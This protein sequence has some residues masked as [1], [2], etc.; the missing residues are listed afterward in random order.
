M[1]D[2][3]LAQGIAA[4]KA[5]NVNEA[6]KLLDIAIRAAPDD[7]RTWGWFYNVCV[8]DEERTRCL[9]QVIRINPNNEIAKKKLGELAAKESGLNYQPPEPPALL[10]SLENPKK[11]YR[12]STAK[13]LTFMFCTPLWTLI[14]IED[15]DSSTAVKIVAIILLLVYGFFFCRLF[16]GVRL[17]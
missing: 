11:W 5:G 12:S 7:E 3:Y 4:V 10:A 8:N 15:P 2:D 6:R 1:A 13:I 17:F 14:I 9:K 16:T